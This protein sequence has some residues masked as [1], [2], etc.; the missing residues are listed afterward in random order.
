MEKQPHIV[1]IVV[2]QMRFDALAANGN[3]LISTPTLDMMAEQGFNFKNTYTAVPSCIASR[4]ALMTGLKQ[5][6]HGRVGFEEGIP[7][8][9]EKMLGKEFTNLGYQTEVIGKLHVYPSRDRIGFEHV[10]LHDGYLHSSR[11][12][13]DQYYSQFAGSD[14][15]L[16]WLST[17]TNRPLDL[18][19]LGLECNSWV[20][21]PWGEEEHLHPTN[22]IASEGIK[23]LNRR[24][25]TKPM[26]LNLS[27]SRPHS[28]LDPPQY[29]FDMYMDRKDEFPELSVGDWVTTEEY[30]Y[31]IDGIKGKLKPDDLDRMRAG[32]YGS[33]THIDYQIN[34]FIMAMIEHQLINDTVFAFVSDHGDQLGEHHLYRKSFPYQ[35]SSHIPFIIYDPGNNITNENYEIDELVEMRDIYPTLIDIAS[36]QK[37]EDIDGMSMKEALLDKRF[38]SRKYIHGEHSYGEYSNQWI[39]TKDWKYAWYP[40]LGKEQLFNLKEDPNEH[41]DLIKN[42]AFK[43]IKEELKARLINELSGREENFVKDGKLVK[44]DETKNTLDFLKNNE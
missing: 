23:F 8:N 42:E 24:D 3:S 19:D 21:R 29:Y 18:T 32:Y 36:N 20:A 44:V 39:V 7:W 22:W 27:F 38:E 43:T 41:T 16:S 31:Q 4:A 25:P 37:V 28:P 40:I 6:N 10:L 13:N 2:D 11:N 14:D 12:V 5:E 9:Y 35:G 33:I 34:R 26:F 17:Q 15:Y 1:L 30:L